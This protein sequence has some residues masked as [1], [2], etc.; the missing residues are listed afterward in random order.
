MWCVRISVTRMLEY[1]R[2]HDHGH[3][4]G[5]GF[6]R[7]F[8]SSSRRVCHVGRPILVDGLPCLWTSSSCGVSNEISLTCP[9]LAVIWPDAR[10]GVPD[11]PLHWAQLPIG[12]QR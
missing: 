12:H 10:F 1:P 8:P 6:G 9:T 2:D 7:F 4:L 5:A 11:E 3:G